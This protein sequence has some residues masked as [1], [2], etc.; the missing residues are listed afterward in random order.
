MTESWTPV[1]WGAVN[2]DL[3]RVPGAYEAQQVREDEDDDASSSMQPSPAGAAVPQ[4]VIQAFLQTH[5]QQLDAHQLASASSIDSLDGSAVAA[6]LRSTSSSIQQQQQQ[7]GKQQ[8][9]ATPDIASRLPQTSRTASRS[10]PAAAGAKRS[11]SSSSS[12]PRKPFLRRLLRALMITGAS[13]GL[14][15]A[16]AWAGSAAYRHYMAQLDDR[17]Q[18]AR[19]VA[20]LKKQE[21]K[22][23][24][25]C[26]AV[27]QDR[28]GLQEQLAQAHAAA[29]EGDAARGRLKSELRQ[30]LADRDEAV[31]LNLKLQ[32]KL[33]ALEDSHAALSA[34]YKDS[35]A[36]LEKSRDEAAWLAK[37]AG[38]L[39]AA[40]ERLEA[41]CADLE[42]VKGELQ[43]QV[44]AL[45][46]KA[47][48]Q[49]Q[50]AYSS[51]SD[52]PLAWLQ[53][54]QRTAAAL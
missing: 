54:L 21:E 14:L 4:D 25:R 48:Q 5:Q 52:L 32:G 44:A 49:R 33:T 53:W 40:V 38:Q 43:Q 1:G 35:Q 29:A 46:T 18:L 23:V 39:A 20:E 47:R 19:R 7:L 28:A 12:R 27:E 34:N 16:G 50:Q 2:P 36:A 37:D 13:A 26:T 30:A 24:L 51:S 6:A 8:P 15:A 10:Q 31:R 3:N 45:T 11:S 17:D 42:S 41:R 22:L 9:P